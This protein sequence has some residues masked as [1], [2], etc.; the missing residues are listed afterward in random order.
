MRTLRCIGEVTVAPT[1][2]DGAGIHY[3]SWGTLLEL[4]HISGA[5]AHYCICLSILCP[6]PLHISVLIPQTVIVKYVDG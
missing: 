5:G 1:V 2:G 4:G 3:W 6:P